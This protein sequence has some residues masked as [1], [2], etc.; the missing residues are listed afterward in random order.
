M[1]LAQLSKQH[2]VGVEQLRFRLRKPLEPG[3]A[4]SVVALEGG[5]LPMIGRHGF[6]GAGHDFG[7]DR[8]GFLRPA[9]PHKDVREVV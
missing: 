7:E 5:P 3:K 9:T 6:L 1:V 8:L 2:A 4:S